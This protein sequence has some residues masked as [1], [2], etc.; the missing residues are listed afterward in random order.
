MGRG[1]GRRYGVERTRSW[2]DIYKRGDESIFLPGGQFWRKTFFCLCLARRR[3]T[4][5]WGGQIEEWKRGVGNWRQRSG[6]FSQGAV[7]SWQSGEGQEEVCSN[8]NMHPCSRSQ[9]GGNETWKSDASTG[10]AHFPLSDGSLDSGFWKVE[11]G[12]GERRSEAVT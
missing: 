6:P 12:E 3:T 8:N 2:Q 9:K 11:K 4:Q 5:G 1:I 7:G 10:E